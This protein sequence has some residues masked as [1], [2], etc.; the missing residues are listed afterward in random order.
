MNSC[1]SFLKI[2]FSV[3]SLVHFNPTHSRSA[4]TETT[5]RHNFP[6]SSFAYFS[7]IQTFTLT[8]SSSF[9]LNQTQLEL[10]RRKRSST[11]A[12]VLK[13]DSRHSTQS[14]SL[15]LSFCLKL[16][17]WIWIWISL[18]PDFARHNS[19]RRFT[20]TVGGPRRALMS[21][22]ARVR[23]W[24]WSELDSLNRRTEQKKTRLAPTATATAASTHTPT[25]ATTNSQAS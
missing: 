6:S 22:C 11:G 2:T 18:C 5:T 10:E 14:L 17:L 1:F 4:K 19:I 8:F 3:L 21:K 16:R 9:T 7:L 20:P 24:K 25:T 12:R 15:S 23:E 13:A